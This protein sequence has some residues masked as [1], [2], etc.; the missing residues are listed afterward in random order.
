MFTEDEFSELMSFMMALVNSH[1]HN[2]NVVL[3]NNKKLDF[4]TIRD[5]MYKYSKKSQNKFFENSVLSFIFAWFAKN[6][7]QFVAEKFSDKDADYQSKIQEEIHQLRD[8]A[9]GS[10]N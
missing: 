2:K 3:K 6:S 5:T 4:D 1:K 7:K 9:V 8:L 10:L